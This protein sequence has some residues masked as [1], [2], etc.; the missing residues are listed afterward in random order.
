MNSRRTIILLVAIV[1]GAIASFGLLIYVRGLEDSA[2]EDAAL[3]TMWVV[4]QEIPRGMPGE[5]AISGGFITQQEVPVQ[6]KPSTAVEDPAVE[7]AS[8]V[9]VTDLPINAPSSRRTS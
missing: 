8:L 6:F 7:L 3:T 2:N 1:V 5:T 4:T 9:A